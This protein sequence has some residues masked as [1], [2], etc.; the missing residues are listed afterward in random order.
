MLSYRLGT[1]NDFHWEFKPVFRCRKH[2]TYLTFIGEEK[3]NQLY[4][5]TLYL[6]HLKHEQKDKKVK[7]ERTFERKMLFLNT[8]FAIVLLPVTFTWPETRVLYIPMTSF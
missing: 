7:K 4:I 2:H 8:L 3:E 6:V 5:N 1:V